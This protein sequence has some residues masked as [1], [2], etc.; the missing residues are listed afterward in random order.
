MISNKLMVVMDP[1]C[2]HQMALARAK[3]LA[4]DL[5]ASLHL[6]CCTYLNEEE[7]GPYSSRKEG[8]HQEI[9]RCKDWLETVADELESEGITASKEVW[10]NEHWA[11]TIS[12]AAAR[13]GASLIVKSSFVHKKGKRL[14]SKTS[15]ITLMRHAPCPVLLAKSDDTWMNQR[16]LAAVATERHDEE[17]ERLNNAIIRQA[18]ALAEATGFELH[19]VAAHYDHPDLTITLYNMLAENEDE[20]IEFIA[21]RFGVPMARVHFKHGT[22]HDV[23]VNTAFEIKADLVIIGT[24]ARSGISGAL[25]GNTAEK[26]LDE[27]ASDLLTVE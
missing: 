13:T 1:T 21:N 26:V 12:H 4:G 16:I 24:S 2:E 22:A 19:L 6:F 15:D 3:Q 7:L 18:Q 20:A 5:K 11:E 27:L 25:I 10:W 9:E 17:H 23:I 14:L 8:K